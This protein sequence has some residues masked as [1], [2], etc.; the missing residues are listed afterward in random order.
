MERLDPVTALRRLGSVADGTTLRQV[1]DPWD[2]RVAVRRGDV[3]HL[4]RNS[5][6]LPGADAAAVAATALHGCTSHLSAALGWGWKVRRPPAVP[7]VTVPRH[8]TVRPERREGVDVR[9]AE[10]SRDELAQGRTSRERTVIDCAR[11]LPFEEAL[12][13]ADSA[14]REGVVTRASLLA[15]AEDS[16]RTG[17]RRAIEVVTAAD[18]RAA[19]P[20]ESCLRA[21]ALQVEGL[22]LEPQLHV[23]GVGHADLGDVRLRILV[24]ADSWEFHSERAAFTYDIRRYTSMVR[25][26][27]TVLRFCWD[28][29]MHRP[30]EV[31]RVLEDVVALRRLAVRCATGCPAA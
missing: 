31:R 29:V 11:T 23:A 21:I 30:D 25:R 3:V 26:G 10:P 16:P 4:G 24:E 19:N 2:L 18:G 5:Y 6:S 12:S 14:L 27:W 17:R 22:S 15:A 28:D 1:C 13:V 8:R 9:W 7:V 20:F